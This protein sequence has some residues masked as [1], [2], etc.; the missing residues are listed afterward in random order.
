MNRAH[1]IYTPTILPNQGMHNQM[2]GDFWLPGTSDLTVL[3]YWK[4]IFVVSKKYEKKFW[5]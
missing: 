2:S 1:L 5:M 3:K 4:I